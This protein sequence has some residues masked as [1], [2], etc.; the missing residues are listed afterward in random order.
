MPSRDDRGTD[1]VVAGLTQRVA[2]LERRLEVE[3]GTLEKRVAE[4][5]TEKTAAKE[6]L[7]SMRD[8]VEEGEWAWKRLEVRARNRR[9]K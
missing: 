5:E 3:V 9:M 2:D 8:A 6:E 4:L 7:K 1:A